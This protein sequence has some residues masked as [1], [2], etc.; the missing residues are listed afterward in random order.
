MTDSYNQNSINLASQANVGD[1]IYI[2][3]LADLN[4][5]APVDGAG[6][7]TIDEEG[8]IFIVGALTL[9]DGERIVLGNRTVLKG[10][11][12]ADLDGILGNVDAPLISG[13]GDGIIVADLFIRNTN[14]GDDAF[15]VET[16]NGFPAIIDG[17][18]SRVEGVSVGGTNGVRIQNATAVQ[19]SILSRCV[20]DGIVL[21]G[22]TAGVQLIG[23]VTVPPVTASPRH[24]VL[25]GGLHQ[26][27]RC[28]DAALVLTD[29][30][31]GIAAQNLPALNLVRIGDTDFIPQ[32]GGGPPGVALDGDIAPG[33]PLSPN[34]QSDVLFISNFGLEE[35]SFSGA[36]AI[37]ENTSEETDILSAGVNTFVRIGSGNPS[38][39]LYQAQNP[40]S[41][42]QVVGTE[43]QNQ[44][45]VY[46]GPEPITANVTAT[47]SVRQANIYQLQASLRIV[48]V[49]IATGIPEPQPAFASVLADGFSGGGAT[50]EITATSPRLTLN[51]GDQLYLEIAN[52]TD[53]GGNP[54]TDLFVTNVALSYDVD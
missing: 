38:H 23:C 48:Y 12:D 36:M 45:L 16:E 17:R 18:A 8:C 33:V 51:P 39:P 20:G 54:L 32:P 2:R 42:F 52:N 43:A 6:V 49:P 40:T 47:M 1:G 11:C 21:R 31:I 24:I 37:F 22:T 53:T 13:S 4:T 46:T 30:A 7:R 19:V 27:F 35:S 29:G 3:S 5:I 28:S 41:R 10:G 34:A 15:C 25:D 44:A 9:P 50:G 26:A 14:P